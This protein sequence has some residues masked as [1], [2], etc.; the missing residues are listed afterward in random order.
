MMGLEEAGILATDEQIEIITDFV[1][2]AFENYGMA[3][4]YDVI[5]CESE[6]AKELKKMKSEAEKHRIYML[7]TMPCHKCNDGTTQ[8]RWGRPMECSNCNGSGRI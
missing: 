4:G 6:E 5:R 2:G 1:K 3:H 8:D 7:T